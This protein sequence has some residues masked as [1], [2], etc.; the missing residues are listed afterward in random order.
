MSVHIDKAGA[1]NMTGGIQLLFSCKRFLAADGGNAPFV[2]G[3]M[4]LQAQLTRRVEENSIVNDKIIHNALD[5]CLASF[6]HCWPWPV[7]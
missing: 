5:S 4:P 2:Y 7:V 6:I 1:D 3:Y